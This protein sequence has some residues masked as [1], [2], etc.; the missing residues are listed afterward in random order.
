MV[1]VTKI[2]NK[3]YK[4]FA[5]GGMADD[6]ARAVRKIR[7]FDALNPGSAL[8]DSVIDEAQAKL[9]KKALKEK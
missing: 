6:A 3:G 4:M 7:Q 1:A 9:L 2:K 8:R 5:E